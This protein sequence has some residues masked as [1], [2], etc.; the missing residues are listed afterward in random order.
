MARRLTYTEGMEIANRSA[1]HRFGHEHWR[2]FVYGRLIT[3]GAAVLGVIGGLAAAWM[4]VPHPILGMVC[5]TLGA[6]PVLVFG[7]RRVS[8]IGLRG[9]LMARAAGRMPVPAQAWAVA[10]FTFTM[11]GAAFLA[12]W[13]PWA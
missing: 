12:L 9:R 8:T 11:F 13:S 5:G 7:L 6:I 1:W 3:R 4:F 2:W 10:G